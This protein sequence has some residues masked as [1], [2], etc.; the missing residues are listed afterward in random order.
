MIQNVETI[1][2][3]LSLNPYNIVVG[4]DH[5]SQIGDVLETFEN[6]KKIAI[7]THPNLVGLYAD[8][9][10]TS[11]EAKGYDVSIIT[12]PVGET[13]KD[14]HKL[15]D[16]VT[17]LLKRKFER[18][19]TLIAVGGGVVGDL[20]G[21]LAASYLRGIN[22]IQ[23]PTTLLAQVDAS[24]G[25]KTGV[26]HEMGKNLIGAFYQPK[27]VYIDTKTLESLPL[28]EFR[29]GMAEVIKYGVIR[30]P[31]LFALLE[32]HVDTLKSFDVN[33][34]S[35]LWRTIITESCKDKA[36]VVAKDEKESNL[37]AILN[38]GHTIGHGIEADAKYTGY[39]HGECVAF[40][41][42]AAT[43]IAVQMKMCS[44]DVLNRI[45]H[46]ISAFGFDTV[47]KGNNVD[48]IMDIMTLDKKVKNGK[49]RFILPKHIGDVVIRDDL[50]ESL[51]RSAVEEVL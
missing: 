30:N 34:R 18:Q 49:M 37:R 15:Y 27:C 51:V 47:A 13:S 7:I 46:L 42:I 17:E 12:V 50:S 1:P 25:G 41:M 5:L 11:C 8:R 6:G 14:F 21:F 22:F 48:K 40:G 35:D 9:V 38:F 45:T 28:R 31:K 19:D 24:I 36:Y 16:L 26:N 44:Q 10:K 33:T 32:K 2:V 39:L 29:S 43:Y 23:V 4:H 20:T 3:Q